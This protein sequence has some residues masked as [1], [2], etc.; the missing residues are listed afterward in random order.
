MERAMATTAA[1]YTGTHDAVPDPCNAT[2][3][4]ID[5]KGAVWTSTGS[6]ARSRCA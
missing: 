5:R 6:P 4:F 1:P 2:N 3:L